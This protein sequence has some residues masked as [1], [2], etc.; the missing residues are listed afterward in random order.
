MQ[1]A[2]QHMFPALWTG[3]PK[4]LVSAAVTGAEP[5]L[6][7]GLP[8]LRVNLAGDH[9]P[10]AEGQARPPSDVLLAVV[11]SEAEAARL[12]TWFAAAGEATPAIHQAGAM[13]AAMPA[14]VLALQSLAEG[15]VRREAALRAALVAAR[16]EAEDTREVLRDLQNRAIGEIGPDIRRLRLERM[17]LGPDAERGLSGHFTLDIMTG[18]ALTGIA[19]VALHLAGHRMAPEERLVVQLIGAESGRVQGEWAVPGEAL[20]NGGW[21]FLDCPLPLPR[22]RETAQLRLSGTLGA[23]S[24]IALSE[25]EFET[26]TGE[27]ETSIAF[28]LYT[29]ETV[30]HVASPHW[31]AGGAAWPGPR[32][33]ALPIATLEAARLLAGE[34]PEPRGN[35]PLRLRVT[36]GTS[37]LLLLPALALADIGEVLARLRCTGGEA[38]QLRAALALLPGA[39]PMPETPEAA[40]AAATLWSAPA[41]PEPVEAL[42]RL[43]LAG[44]MAGAAHLLIALRHLGTDPLDFISAEL[45]GVHL[46]PLGEAPGPAPR[47]LFGTAAPGQAST[48]EFARLR[49]DEVYQDANYRHLDLSIEEL[50]AGAAAWPHVKFK[51]SEMRG[52]QALEFRRG[53]GWPE[54]FRRFPEAKRDAYGEVWR[55]GDLARAPALIAALPQEVDRLL[56][57]TLVGLLPHLVQTLA[58]Q[59]AITPEAAASWRLTRSAPR[60]GGA[61]G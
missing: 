16:E 36:G 20:P 7:P 59:R 23:G 46:I 25:A 42:L 15:A 19:A 26:E 30:Q 34:A 44:T 12:L 38:A 40:L 3:M 21:L 48:V 52:V 1:E 24:R 58:T 11:A 60:P 61:D 13:S 10:Q 37:L 14:L 35:L 47:A 22:I 49:L 17:P 50:R 57:T 41:A 5:A 39:Q 31:R 54:M 51:L 9:P 27:I 29:A 55:L 45:D 8:L 18:A 53:P 43:P 6:L 32:P 28:R 33:H 4:L 56:L 2:G